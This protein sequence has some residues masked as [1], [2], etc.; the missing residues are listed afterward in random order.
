MAEFCNYCS[1]DL[2]GPDVKPEIDIEQVYEDLKNDTCVAVLCEGCGLSAIG[3]SA[4]GEMM[5]GVLV[6][7]PDSQMTNLIWLSQD[8]FEE[9]RRK[10]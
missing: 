9:Q 1:L 2:F 3:K 6:D 8:S 5:M 10:H 7:E 4:E